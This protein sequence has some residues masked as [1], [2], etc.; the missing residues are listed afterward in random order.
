MTVSE[1]EDDTEQGWEPY[2]GDGEDAEWEV[3]AQEEEDIER[4]WEDSLARTEVEE[5][6]GRAIAFGDG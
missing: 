3:G 2:A 4:E 6:E 1:A 5:E